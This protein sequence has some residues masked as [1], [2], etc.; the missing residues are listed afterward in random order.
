MDNVLFYRDYLPVLKKTRATIILYQL[1][2]VMSEKIEGERRCKLSYKAIEEHTGLRIDTISKGNS[3]LEKLGLITVERQ[4]RNEYII[5]ELKPLT[6]EQKEYYRD[7]LSTEFDTEVAHRLKYE[8]EYSILLDHSHLRMALEQLGSKNFTITNVAQFFDKDVS[9]VKEAMRT[10]SFEAAVN[11][12]FESIQSGEE[13]DEYEEFMQVAK[14]DSA[15]GILKYFCEKFV[16]RYSYR[17]CFKSSLWTG[18]EY[19][20]CQSLLKIFNNS[21]RAKQYIDFILTK[22]ADSLPLGVSSVNILLTPSLINEFNSVSC[23]KHKKSDSVPDSVTQKAKQYNIQCD[24]Y[25]Q[26]YWL[27]IR[28]ERGENGERL[29]EF[30]QWVRNE[31]VLPMQG[32]IRLQ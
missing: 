13:V 16:E 24:T 27:V 14:E 7:K 28:S 29:K 15:S 5:H 21:Q 4:S 30:V 6:E 20:A 19:Q 10:Y 8:D 12:A 25:E 23:K 1:Y 32:N 31:G 17:Y 26:L 18:P 11:Q 9:R 22:K 2:N 3:I